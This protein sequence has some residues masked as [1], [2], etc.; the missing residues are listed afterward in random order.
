MWPHQRSNG[1]IQHGCLFGGWASSYEVGPNRK[2]FVKARLFLCKLQ[3]SVSME[4]RVGILELAIG[5]NVDR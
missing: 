1:G 3:G 2:A 5:E 4:R